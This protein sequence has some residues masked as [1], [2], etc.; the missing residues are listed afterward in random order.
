MR[1]EATECRRV[2]GWC[3]GRYGDA[4]GGQLR[5][6]TTIEGHYTLLSGSLGRLARS[7][8]AYLSVHIEK[9]L[10]H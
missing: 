10:M 9:W 5:K 2:S 4:E 1:S 8:P 6:P 3:N 7:T